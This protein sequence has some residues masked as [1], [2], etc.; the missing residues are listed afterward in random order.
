MDEEAVYITVNM[1]SFDNF[2]GAM[3]GVRLWIVD[4][5]VV[6]GFYGGGAA[7]V[8]VHDPYTGGGWATTTMPAHVFDAGG[9]PGGAGDIGTFLV[10]Y[11][12]ITIGGPGALESVQVVRVDDP[13]GASG[14][15][16]FTQELVTVGDIADVGGAFGFPDF[17]AAPQLG[18]TEVI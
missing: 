15:P 10:S 13:L 18:C 1:F 3:G 9:V 4:K 14:G 11:S 5:G 17:P 2:G 16:V 7:T 8:T 12:S 6:S